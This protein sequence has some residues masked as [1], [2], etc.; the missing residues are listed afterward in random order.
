MNKGFMGT[1]VNQTFYSCK[2]MV[3]LKML[4]LSRYC[5]GIHRRI[6]VYNIDGAGIEY[7][8]DLKCRPNGLA[9]LDNNTV[10]VGGE[11]TKVQVNIY[12]LSSSLCWSVFLFVCLYVRSQLR[13]S[14]TD[15]P[16]ILIEELGGGGGTVM[17]LAWS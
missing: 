13:I 6:D 10:A 7:T 11:S 5:V 14:W 9:F 3:T 16:Q 15:L 12:I 17:F 1:I 8:I 4:L 2:G